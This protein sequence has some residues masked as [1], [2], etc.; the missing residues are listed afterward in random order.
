MADE[1]GMGY[2]LG[3]DSGG[4]NNGG[5]FFGNEGLWA[6]IILAIIFGWGRNGFGGNGG[7]DGSGSLTRADICDGFN[8][9]NLDS[10]VRG[11]QNG[12][13]D[14]FY[15]ANSSL[16]SGFHGVDNAICTLGYQTQS[17]LNALSAQMAQCCCDTRAAIGD[18]KYQMA[19]DTCA[20]T[21]TIQSTTRDI[22]DNQNAGTRAILDYLCQEKISNLQAENQTLRLAAS[23][24]NQNAVL[25]AAM[26]ANKAEILRRTGNDCP[27]AAYV[28]P[29]PNCC[30]GNP[31][32]VS[33][34][35]FGG[36]GNCGCGCG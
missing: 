8:F 14:G 29:N 31:V 13:C 24:S 22:I 11:V 1:F 18:I 20:I 35:N 19:T 32:G 7:G 23:Q 27:V 30:Y 25:M 26:D 3:Q 21:N 28:V 33:Y 17:G 16:M 12:L 34:G 36:N 10:A 2:A 4:G 15:A 5:G 9:N 6:V